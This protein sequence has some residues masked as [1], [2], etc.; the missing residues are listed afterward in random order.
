MI[1]RPHPLL[2][3]RLEEKGI[4]S[5]DEIIDFKRKI[6]ELGN[7]YIDEN[8]E[9]MDSFKESDALIT[10]AGSFLLE[11]LWVNKP[12]LYTYPPNGYGLNDD[13]EIIL[14]AVITLGENPLQT[15]NSFI[16]NA[17]KENQDLEEK[18]LLARQKLFYN[19]KNGMSVGEYIIKNIVLACKKGDLFVAPVSNFKRDI[20]AHQYWEKSNN[21][22]LGTKNYY[23]LQEKSFKNFLTKIG[24]INTAVDI[25]CGDGRFTFLL[26]NFAKNV[27]A[28]DISEKLLAK[29]QSN[30][31]KN[32]LNNIT[33]FN[34]SILE[35]KELTR[36][37]LV[38]CMGVLSGMVSEVRFT[39]ALH[40]LKS[41]IN[42]N[43]GK[44]ILK[45]SL[46]KGRPKYSPIISRYTCV[47]RNYEQY[48][49]V[50]KSLGFDLIQEE[51]L[52]E[53]KNTKLVNS[54]FLFALKDLNSDSDEKRIKGKNVSLDKTNI[55]QFFKDRSLKNNN[56]N[57]YVSVIYQDGN[58]RLALKRDRYEKNL[59]LP[60]LNLDSSIKLLDI[61]CGI[62]RWAD[63]INGKIDHYLGIDF[64]EDLIKQA[65]I[66]FQNTKS[67]IDFKVCA[68]E[69]ISIEKIGYKS[70]FNRIIISGVLLYLNDED[71]KRCFHN[72]RTLISQNSLIYIR[73][74]L[75]L[76]NER[77]TLDGVWSKDMSQKYYAIY[78]TKKEIEELFY[79]SFGRIQDLKLLPLYDE[80]NLNNRKETKQF[81]SVFSLAL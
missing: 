60:K 66:R 51:I 24:F 38:S 72:L 45:E 78:R 15:I 35:I 18:R 26:A 65:T 4:W 9:Y 2:W 33:F 20:K 64:S 74:P 22:Y 27:H 58:P 6:A 16:F 81:Y 70:Y 54:L 80:E 57:P 62:G 67:K 56:L 11:Y 53:D 36:Y 52:Y 46:I 3:N 5:Y 69:S 68:A 14:N 79:K 13:S 76:N 19:P 31:I 49:N 75:S 29:A 43:G 40:Y 47:Y 77:L 30:A 8:Y 61:G 50:I 28:C 42:T 55:K 32:H 12:I 23:D 34:E 59:I 25:G 73:E 10:D 71:V 37:D 21:T 17:K 63:E 1:F 48:I 7:S 44:L 41:L 39:R